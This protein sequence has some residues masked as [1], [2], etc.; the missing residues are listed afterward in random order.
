MSYHAEVGRISHELAADIPLVNVFGAIEKAIYRCRNEQWLNHGPDHILNIAI[1]YLLENGDE[2]AQQKALELLRIEALLKP[3]LDTAASHSVTAKDTLFESLEMPEVAYKLFEIAG[4]H[5]V[6]VA[7]AEEYTTDPLLIY[8]FGEVLMR[9]EDCSQDAIDQLG[10]VPRI[11]GRELIDS[12]R[13]AIK[14]NPDSSFYEVNP[15]LAMIVSTQRQVDFALAQEANDLITDIYWKTYDLVPPVPVDYSGL[16]ADKDKFQSGP[17]QAILEMQD[18]DNYTDKIKGIE[19]WGRILAETRND[20]EN[21]GLGQLATFRDLASR[22]IERI[23]AI[24]ADYFKLG[25]RSRGYDSRPRDEAWLVAFAGHNLALSHMVS[26]GQTAY[27]SSLY[28]TTIAKELGRLGDRKALLRMF[29]H[30]DGFSEEF[31]ATLLE[32]FNRANQG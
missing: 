27:N 25:E 4:Q 29:K 18:S 28:F 15:G 26:Y 8:A 20:L 13:I 1:H 19:E 31:K 16:L 12:A 21:L 22:A 11:I 9:A 7:T 5:I 32:H 10:F 24:R 6:G 2:L 14:Q 17:I 30:A 23:L 3:S